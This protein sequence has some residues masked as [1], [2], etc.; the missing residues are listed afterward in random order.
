[1][2]FIDC[3]VDDEYHM[4]FECEAFSDSRSEVS[5]C[6]QTSDGS[7]RNLFMQGDFVKVYKFVSSCMK[8]I[9]MKRA[10]PVGHGRAAS[11]G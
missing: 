7:I 3:P 9:D 6:I 4:I 5:E 8:A 11:P 10:L 1:M 2:N